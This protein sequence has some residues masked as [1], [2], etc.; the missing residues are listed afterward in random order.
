MWLITM[1]FADSQP[2]FRDFISGVFSQPIWLDTIECAGDELSLFDCR[3]NA[4]GAQ[5]CDHLQDAGVICSGV[6][7]MKIVSVMN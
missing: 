2:I 1:D 6:L 7:G 4:I 5:S 3:R